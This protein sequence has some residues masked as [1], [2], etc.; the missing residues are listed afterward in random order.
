M[1]NII[2]VLI[3]GVEKIGFLKH[4][5]MVLTQIE[6]FGVQMLFFFI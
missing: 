4:F 5:L 1:V 3:T 2:L 6:H